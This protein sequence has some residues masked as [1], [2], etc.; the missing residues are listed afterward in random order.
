MKVEDSR[1][2]PNESA[3]D[4]IGRAETVACAGLVDHE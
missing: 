4:R 1:G 2:C 3:A